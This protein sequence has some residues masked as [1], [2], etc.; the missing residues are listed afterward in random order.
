M[1]DWIT[2]H[3]QYEH[4][5]SEDMV[6]SMRK[7]IADPRQHRLCT[8]DAGFQCGCPFP[9]SER[10]ARAFTRLPGQNDCYEFQAEKAKEF[11]GCLV[12]QSLIVTGR[13]E[14]FYLL[15]NRHSNLKEWEYGESCQCVRSEHGWG[16]FLDACQNAYIATNFMLA[17]TDHLPASEKQGKAKNYRNSHAWKLLSSTLQLQMQDDAFDGVFTEFLAKERYPDSPFH[18][19]SITNYIPLSVIQSVSDTVRS[20]LRRKGLANETC[21]HILGYV[22]TR[23]AFSVH[24]DPLHLVNRRALNDLLHL[25]WSVIV[26]CKLLTRKLERA[27]DRSGE[28]ERRYSKHIHRELMSY[29]NAVYE[30]PHRNA[31]KYED[32]IDGDDG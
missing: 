24:R 30:K 4:M 9:L 19:Y 31:P 15:G 7:L 23:A 11:F 32:Y 18:E 12:M 13:L 10:R 20:A 3:N 16:F 8:H 29:A 6:Q 17:L 5:E 1:T 25:L 14:P 28:V 22:G 2:A 27:L 21:D 26:R